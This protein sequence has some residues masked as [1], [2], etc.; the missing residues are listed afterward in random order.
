MSQPK[1]TISRADMEIREKEIRLEELDKLAN[2][3]ILLRDSNLHGNQL[4]LNLSCY[5]LKRIKSL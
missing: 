3:I 4:A 1:S 2:E 5:I